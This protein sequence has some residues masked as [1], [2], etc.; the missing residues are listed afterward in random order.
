[1]IRLTLI[2]CM[3]TFVTATAQDSVKVKN[4]HGEVD[5]SKSDSI[6][7]GALIDTINT[8]GKTEQQ[9]KDMAE[10]GDPESSIRNLENDL[11]FIKAS[12]K[13]NPNETVSRQVTAFENSKNNLSK[14]IPEL[15]D[16][17]SKDQWQKDF[18]DLKMQVD[19][20]KMS[21]H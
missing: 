9:T 3:L 10:P 11:S 5:T 16:E 1:M 21:V 18:A 15:K 12:L 19:K 4:R 20:L 6:G 7:T 14:R 13:K 2:I 8:N 17:K